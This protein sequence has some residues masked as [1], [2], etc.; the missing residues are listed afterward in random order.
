[1]K[2]CAIIAVFQ[3][4]IAY[5]NY[6]LFLKIIK[7]EDSIYCNVLFVPYFLQKCYNQNCGAGVGGILVQT[8]EELVQK[9]TTMMPEDI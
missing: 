5:A 7:F 2:K 9:L 1:M 3:T 6:T 8:E 4:L